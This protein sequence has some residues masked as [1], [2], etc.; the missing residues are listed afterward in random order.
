MNQ[1]CAI[2]QQFLLHALGLK[3]RC[4]VLVDLLVRI[5]PTQILT[6]ELNA[7]LNFKF[8]RI[9]KET[10]HAKRHRSLNPDPAR[11]IP[12]P[13]PTLAQTKQET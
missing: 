13:I 12:I 5:R 10:S 7:H 1:R 9:Y 11:P 2:H 3:S 4:H 8:R 6:I